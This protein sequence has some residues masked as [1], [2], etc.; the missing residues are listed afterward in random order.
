MSKHI[1]KP[2]LLAL[3]FALSAC[4]TAPTTT[5]TLEQARSDYAMAQAN[6]NVAKY[7]SMEMASATRSLD[8]ANTAAAQNK[9]LE[10]IDKLAY[11]AKQKVASAQE[12]ARAK[13]AEAQ[14]ANA[15]QQRDQLRLEARTAEADAAK[16]QA[17]EAAAAANA[18]Q[19]Q[20]ANAEQRANNLAQQLADLQAKQT[21]RGIVI[22]FGDVLFNTDQAMLTAQGMQTAQRLADV[23]RNNPDRSVLIE[24]FTDSTGTASH[25]LELSQRRAESVR[26]ALSQMGVDRSRIDTRGYGEAYPVASNATASDRQLNRRVEIV[27]SEAGRP[28]ITR[29]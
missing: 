8:Q 20:A 7:A 25:N 19:S 12:I 4:S 10:E 6:P 29:R 11:V 23:L 5:S 15:A 24:G 26:M 27:L 2:M 3:A 28:P 18:A 17:D 13:A 22:T 16:R 1:I 9:S 21:E 14:V